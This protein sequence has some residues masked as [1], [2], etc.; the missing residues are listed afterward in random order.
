MYIYRDPKYTDMLN[1][2]PQNCRQQTVALYRGLIVL[3]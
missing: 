2:L 3:F 1:I